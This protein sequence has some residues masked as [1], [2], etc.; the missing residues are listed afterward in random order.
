MY[1]TY[2]YLYRF[3]LYSMQ[4]RYILY[5][6]SIYL[7]KTFIQVLPC[8]VPCCPPAVLATSNKLNLV[9]FVVFK[10]PRTCCML[11]S[12]EGYL[13]FCIA[14]AA[15]CSQSSTSVPQFNH[16]QIALVFYLSARPMRRRRKRCPRNQRPFVQSY[17]PKMYIYILLTCTIDV[18]F[19]MHS[20]TYG[21]YCTY[22]PF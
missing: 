14:S 2:V 12:K 9:Y 4:K 17:P 5:S 21:M 19:S 13:Q 3:S 1:N 20:L 16:D 8:F 22:V 18:Q 15:P 7:K 11:N 6:V 10:P